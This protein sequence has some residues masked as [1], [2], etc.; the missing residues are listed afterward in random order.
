MQANQIHALAVVPFDYISTLLILEIVVCH[1]VVKT[2]NKPIPA[3][4]PNIQT[5]NC[6]GYLSG[7]FFF[8]CSATDPTFNRDPM[9]LKI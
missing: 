8:N 7:E 3:S 1:L 9:L 2:K 5:S 4:C 6:N